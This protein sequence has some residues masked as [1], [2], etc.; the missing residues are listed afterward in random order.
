MATRQLST[1]QVVNR[2]TD[3]ATGTPGELYYNTT[4]NTFK[5]YNGTV[6]TEIVGGSEGASLTVSETAPEPAES[7]DLW[8]NSA[9]LKLLVY[10]D[11][12]WVEI[13]G[14]G[15]GG[16][17]QNVVED[18]T[19]EL[20]GNLD[21]SS[22]NITNV[23][24]LSFDT[25][26]DNP[27]GVGTLVWDD[28][29]GTLKLG[30]KG[31]EVSLQLG[32]ENVALCYNGTGSTIANGSVVYIS[33]AQGQRPSIALADADTESTSSKT[34]GIATE[35]I[36]NGAEGFVATFGIVNGLNTSAFTAGQALWLSSTAGQLTNIKPSAP[37]HAV[38]VGYC[39]HVNA[40]SGRVFVNPQNG[41]EVDELHDVL[42]TSIADNHI[43]SYDNA[44]SLWKNQGLA[45]AIQEV[46]GP[47][48]GIDADLLDG[49]HGSYY[50]PIDSPALTGTPTAP[51]APAA[52]NT[53]QIATTA[54]VRT[55]VANLVDSAPATLDTLN[56]L[57]AA[58]GDD[59]NFA[60]TVT[61]AL[62]LK[63]PLAS[64]T[65][66]GTVTVPTPVNATDAATKG[67]VDSLAVEEVYY[68]ASAPSSIPVGTIWIESDVDVPETT[69]HAAYSADAPAGPITGD[70]WI[71]SDVDS[72]V[73]QP[74]VITR[75]TENVSSSKTLFN[76]GFTY[77]VGYEQV[78]LNGVLLSRNS[79]YTA[80]DGTSITLAETA[81]AGDVVEIISTITINLIDS[82]TQT[83]IDSALALK[84]NIASPTFT[85]TPLAPTAVAGTNTTQ[86]AT[87]AFTTSAITAHNAA[88][89]IH[90]VTG[91]VVG[92]TDSQ[93]LTNKTLSANILLSPE[94]RCNI[95]A[96]AATG[97]INFDVL[98]STIWFYTSNAAA[99]H[100]L[101]FRGNS[102]TTLNSI[103]AVGDS[104]SLI[105]LN[106]NGGTAYRP[107]AFQ[108][109]GVSVTPRWSGGTAPTAGNANSIDAY[110][111]SIIK[112]AASTYTV[113]AGQVR[114]A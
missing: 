67:Y 48:S 13:G 41:Y 85:G 64:P 89:G 63:A 43:L 80:T 112:T 74:T 113:L 30:L 108:I 102:G 78:F 81:R 97:T 84:A 71:E 75:Y 1:K 32:Q 61:N 107:T 56:E 29:E 76:S 12:F 9:T 100:T 66:T 90:G 34:F 87:T 82:Y 35:D 8:L 31:G 26:P 104:I 49:Q 65:F 2:A 53:T 25:T 72:D 42:I 91:S 106:T 11:S 17:L 83:Q 101:N 15:G 110:S 27:G 19:P 5:Y 77:Q 58:L 109:D 60:T 44:T 68:Q 10:Y 99:D 33:G 24:N 3:P 95:V 62:S 20:G 105:W 4:S 111:F 18:T 47:S 73:F 55:E 93:T 52:T 39:L 103:L 50:A 23:D 79:D 14:G 28:G 6:W 59:P 96:A 40:S 38:F 37:T 57:A 92:T 70:L 88:S 36:A 45:A 51:T 21:A 7:G 22:F 98:T 46:D 54:F 94:E 69:Y 16:G 86:I 114:F